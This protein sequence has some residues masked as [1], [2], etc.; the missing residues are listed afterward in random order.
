[1]PFFFRFDLD[2]FLSTGECCH[3]ILTFSIYGSKQ[4]TFPLVFFDPHDAPRHFSKH[5]F[6]LFFVSKQITKPLVFFEPV[7][8][9]ITYAAIAIN[10]DLRRTNM[11]CVFFNFSKSRWIQNIPKYPPKRDISIFGKLKMRFWGILYLL[12]WILQQFNN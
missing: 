2:R 12:T 4:I 9:S 6:F 1:M 7:F 8:L 3:D 11:L 10:V 5:S